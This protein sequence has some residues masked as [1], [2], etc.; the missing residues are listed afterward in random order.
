ML[1][2]IQF[3]F[4]D[5]RAFINSETNRLPYPTWPLPEVNKEFIR[6]SGVVS[7]RV[8]G[9]LK[10][11]PSEEVYCDARRSLRFEPPL[12][13]QHMGYSG[14]SV[15]LICRFRRFL[16]D[17]EAVARVEVGLEVPSNS[18]IFKNGRLIADANPFPFSE[19]DS[20]DL[21]GAYLSIPVRIPSAEGLPVSGEL[22]A[23]GRHLASH[24]LRSTTR[25]VG[26]NLASTED[27]WLSAGMP[28]LVI[29]YQGDEVGY[30]PKYAREVELPSPGR[31][32]CVLE[33]EPGEIHELPKKYAQ[34]L[35]RLEHFLRGL[36]YCNIE[37]AGKRLGVWFMALYGDDR[38]LIRRLR[39][40]LFRV[41]AERECLKQVLRLIVRDKLQP[42]VRTPSSDRLQ[43]Y[44]QD[45]MRLLSRGVRY[46]LPQSMILEEAQKAEDLVSPGE[47]ATL[48]AQLSKINIRKNI[49]HTLEEFSAA[50]VDSV[51]FFHIIGNNTPIFIG[52]EQRIGG[53]D[54]T[55]YEITFG[56]NVKISGDFV[57]ANTIQ[58][59][60]N[61]ISSSDVSQALKKELKELSEAVAEMCNHLPQDKAREA[62]R[63]LETLTNEAVSEK[64]RRRWYE[65]SAK[66]LIEAAKVA[67]QV[68]AP[69]IA[70]VNS[71]LMIL[72]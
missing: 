39:L 10:S 24:Y 69:V 70:I 25:R 65:L 60:F 23:S 15:S 67:G 72:T 58:S 45:S 17:G 40:H 13:R 64:P 32:L 4:A 43:H 26:G 14:K 46:G 71:L 31:P 22:F 8:A 53:I 63:D 34:S 55:K 1:I 35:E 56:D 11:W 44:L 2:T 38:D 16:F 49:Y 42:G 57:V 62:V 37:R 36:Y 20:L 6:T 27:W 18:P 59:S 3:P 52:K 61:K 41:H 51:Q 48:L 9:G 28:L 66:G 7:Y 68:A 47:R 19:Q 5:T 21:I 12:G 29:E 54:M 33:D 30:P 50:S